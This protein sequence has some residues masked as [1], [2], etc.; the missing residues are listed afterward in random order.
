MV[1]TC[2]ECAKALGLIPQHHKDEKINKTVLQTS[3]LF[4]LNHYILIN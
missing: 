2:I 4:T 1:C 3:K